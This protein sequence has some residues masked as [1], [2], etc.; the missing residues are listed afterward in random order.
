MKVV[1][2]WHICQEFGLGFLVHSNLGHQKLAHAIIHTPALLSS[3]L[4]PLGPLGISPITYILLFSEMVEEPGSSLLCHIHRDTRI[5]SSSFIMPCLITS[6]SGGV[7][8]RVSCLI[9]IFYC[10]VEPS[11]KGFPSPPSCLPAPGSSFTSYRDGI[12]HPDWELLSFIHRLYRIHEM[13]GHSS[14]HLLACH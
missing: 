2:L 10:F 8:K 4:C 5:S 1:I 9:L 11:P 3:F 6:A 13:G 12:E 7:V 14:S